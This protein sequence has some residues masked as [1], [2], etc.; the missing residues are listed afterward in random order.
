MRLLSLNSRL[1]LIN[2]IYY[3]NITYAYES[4]SIFNATLREATLHLG[5]ADVC[6]CMQSVGITQCY[7]LKGRER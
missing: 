6:Q 2:L 4:S 3:L 5:A 1:K 7:G